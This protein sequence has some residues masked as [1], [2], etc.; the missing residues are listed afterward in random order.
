MKERIILVTMKMDKN[1]KYGQVMQCLK[2]V[3]YRVLRSKEN[4]VE[5]CSIEGVI[6][7]NGMTRREDFS[8]VEK[9]MRQSRVTGKFNK[10]MQTFFKV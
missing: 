7:I 3:V 2:E 9:C 4:W 10:R 8:E 5:E 1:Q 6:R